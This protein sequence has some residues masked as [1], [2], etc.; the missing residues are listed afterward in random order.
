MDPTGR[1]ILDRRIVVLALLQENSGGVYEGYGI[2]GR[3]RFGRVALLCAFASC[4]LFSPH[5]VAD[6]H[7]TQR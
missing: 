6:D 5:K 2:R 3:A 1:V 4:H 7:F